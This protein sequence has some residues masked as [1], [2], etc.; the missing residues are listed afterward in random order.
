MEIVVYIQAKRRLE[1]ISATMRSDNTT[2]FDE[3]PSSVGIASITDVG[4]NLLIQ[5]SNYNY[6]TLVQGVSRS[7]ISHD[8]R[9]A[10]E[11]VEQN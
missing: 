8:Q 3:M 1:T 5:E 11:L 4:Q 10:R 6:P 9:K 2:W 7:S